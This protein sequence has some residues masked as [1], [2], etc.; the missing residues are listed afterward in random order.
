MCLER[1]QHMAVGKS[2]EAVK[3]TQASNAVE[4]VDHLRMQRV[5]EIEH[6]VAVG[7]ESVGEERLARTE[8]VLSVMR[9]E[10]F[11]VDGCRCNDGSVAIAVSCEIDDREE[12][13]VLSILIT[14]PGKEVAGRLRLRV[15]DGSRHQAAS[16]EGYYK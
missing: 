8:F 11:F 13:A 6:Q 10:S 3:K 2:R 4:P 7:R 14:G 16:G 9:P 5:V 12:V 15:I 1:C